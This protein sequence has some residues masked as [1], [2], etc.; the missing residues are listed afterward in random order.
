MNL[1]WLVFPS[2]QQSSERARAST[3]DFIRL[4]GK[5]KL[6]CGVDGSRKIFFASHH[7]DWIEEHQA[8]T[9]TPRH[10]RHSSKLHE[11]RDN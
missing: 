5:M 6:L 10:Q 8:G 11:K 1:V 7:F 3:N 9:N 2:G 4:I